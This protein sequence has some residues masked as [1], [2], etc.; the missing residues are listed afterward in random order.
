MLSRRSG[1][2]ADH[3]AAELEARENRT[4]ARLEAQRRTY[5][6]HPGF[7]CDVLAYDAERDRWDIVAT[8]P[9]TPQVT[10]MAVRWVE[11]IVIPSGEISP[12]VRPP[13]I[14]RIRLN[15]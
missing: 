6:N 7:S 4:A 3:D 8:S 11:D 9:A 12:G 1:A 5:E 15:P 10:T 2:C 13:A 14:V